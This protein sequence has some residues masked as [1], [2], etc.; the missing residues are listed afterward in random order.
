MCFSGCIY[1]RW[2]GEPLGKC[3]AICP[4]DQAVCGDCCRTFHADELNEDGLCK[5]CERENDEED[6]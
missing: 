1:E 6:V 2:D 5:Y 3:P 4:H